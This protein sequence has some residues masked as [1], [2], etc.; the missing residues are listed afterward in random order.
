MNDIN[1][2]YHT[3][4]MSKEK[5]L[6]RWNSCET[7]FRF[8]GRS[9]QAI[10]TVIVY[11]TV[12]FFFNT[13][14]MADLGCIRNGKIMI[15]CSWEDSFNPS[16]GCMIKWFGVLVVSDTGRKYCLKDGY[17][18]NYMYLLFASQERKSNAMRKFQIQ[19]RFTRD[20]DIKRCSCCR[21]CHCWQLPMWARSITLCH[22]HNF[23]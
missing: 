11:E 6:K 15:C 19:T 12:L 7:N 16:T 10:C 4:E 18:W 13:I 5:N 8:S 2:S 14:L 22:V 17:E 1:H 21:S 23:C 9:L 3:V 20:T